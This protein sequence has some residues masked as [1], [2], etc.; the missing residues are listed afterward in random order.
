MLGSGGREEGH[1]S[2]VMGGEGSGRYLAK[3]AALLNTWSQPAQHCIPAQA[4]VC[5]DTA[6][7]GYEVFPWKPSSW[8]ELQHE[9]EAAFSG[10]NAT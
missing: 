1:K 6:A 10:E 7:L 2:L 3:S 9:V 4:L 5:V 8:I